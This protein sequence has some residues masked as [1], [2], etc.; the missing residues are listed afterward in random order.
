MKNSS[1]AYGFLTLLKRLRRVLLQDTALLRVE[2]PD[3]FLF[4][5]KLFDTKIYKA[6][7]GRVVTGNATTETPMSIQMG[8][9]MPEMVKHVDV[10]RDTMVGGMKDLQA[11]FSQ[12]ICSL[13]NNLDRLQDQLD[14]Y[15]EEDR[16]V[17]GKALGNLSSGIHLLSSAVLETRMV[18]PG[19][20]PTTSCTPL[21]TDP[22]LH[23]APGPSR[24]VVDPSSA[25]AQPSSTSS[26]SRIFAALERAG[27]DGEEMF[28]MEGASGGPAGTGG[29]GSGT[30][31]G[32]AGDGRAAGGMASG[33][34]ADTAGEKLFVMEKDH[35][36]VAD[37]WREYEVGVFGRRS[38]R[39]MH[40]DDWK[41]A[42]C[43]R[44]RWE[45]RRVVITEVIRLA[46]ERTTSAE[47]VVRD[48]DAFIS[49]EKLSM[50]RLQDRIIQAKKAGEKLPI[51]K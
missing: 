48:L 40:A 45:R 12:D 46:A 2:H 30:V 33:Q 43:Q 49:Q 38:L 37:L 15:R 10:A 26:A 1:T 32:T 51:W 36:T 20:P 42:E 18:F 24:P 34:R 13:S 39:E 16:R 28:R 41:K 35:R 9:V 11:A 29:S 47:S 21:N 27:R 50:T 5:N 19:S 7:A 14:D 4:R 23:A 6:Y 17:M 25:A 22:D 8:Q 3:H 44:K 31:G